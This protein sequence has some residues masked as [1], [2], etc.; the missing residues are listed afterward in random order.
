[1]LKYLIEKEFKQL[2]RN[3]FLP[4]LIVIM[5][6]LVML[7]F[8]WTTTMEIKNIKLAVVDND[9][10]AVSKMLVDKIVASGYFSISEY[11]AD[12]DAALHEVE[13][14]DADV[15]VEIP[16][17]FEDDLQREKRSAVSV[18][19]NAVNATKANLGTSYISSIIQEFS[20]DYMSSA[21][22]SM[23]H[24]P[25]SIGAMTSI[26]G[27]SVIPYYRFNPTMDYKIPMIPALIVLILTLMC[28]FLP[29][30]NVVGEKETGTIE[31]IN[32]S[33]V[34]KWAFIV[35]KLLPFWIIGLLV[36]TIAMA[37]SIPLY[38]LV[39][40]GSILLIY[41]LSILFIFAVS[42]MG[43]IVSNYSNTLQQAN[44]VIF[45]LIIVMLLI[46]GLFTPI[47]SMPG[48]AQVLAYMSPLTYFVE[49]NKAIYLK[50]SSLY[51]I[52]PQVLALL[53]FF[54]LFTVW[55]VLSYKK[56]S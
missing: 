14:G 16:S 19:A 36:L 20:V 1:M 30:L 10:S 51:D 29:A 18:S 4:K 11:Y 34:P 32:V 22:V 24:Y 8:P 2:V 47:E 48:W 56:R 52:Y 31:Q 35:G 28:G 49:I 46:S 33:P 12:Y 45:F 44:F 13:V 55:A 5:P 21:S 39:P 43:L 50:G 27:I 9:N 53:G 54:V 17:G 41:G 15:V 3:P 7:I 40:K 6:C 26:G 37:I 38:H 23:T 25:K 42:G